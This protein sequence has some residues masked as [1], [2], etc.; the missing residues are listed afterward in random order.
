MAEVIDFPDKLGAVM[1]SGDF[2]SAL[3]E[4]GLA[5]DTR[6]CTTGNTL[7]NHSSK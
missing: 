4:P 5:P 1:A 7:P 2:S 3:A 6:N